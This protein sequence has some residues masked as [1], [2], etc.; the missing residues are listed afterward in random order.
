MVG[1][2][3]RD[4]AFMRLPSSLASPPTR[5][6]FGDRPGLQL[7][8][9]DPARIDPVAAYALFTG[10]PVDV[11]TGIHVIGHEV[12]GGLTLWIALREPGFCWLE[13][14]GPTADMQ[15]VPLLFALP[16]KFR[17][18]A[19]VFDGA[20]AGL[21]MRP[22][23]DS[24]PASAEPEPRSFELHIRSFGE[25]GDSG[26]RLRQHAQAWDGAGR[27]GAA[28][29]RI[30]ALPIDVGYTPTAQE[31]VVEKRW[32]RLVLD[33]PAQTGRDGSR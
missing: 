20:S 22:P 7:Y 8:V 18:A 5:V 29:L 17:S 23:G 11:P 9:R 21:C 33:W 15:P 12:Y 10:P 30:R 16:G 3:I 2:P 14:L 32:T 1:A 28:G 31:Q 24:V 27:P 19:G 6:A 4:C 25:D 26:W 13:A